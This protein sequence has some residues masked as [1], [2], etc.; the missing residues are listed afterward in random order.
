MSQQ[1]LLLQ[2]KGLYT[3][4]NHLSPQDTPQGG[5]LL[6]SNA[7]IDRNSIINSRR[8]YQIY[9][10]AMDSTVTDT[11]HQLLNYKKRLFR[12]WGIAAGQYLDWD[13]GTG[14]FS[15]FSFSLTASTNSN[16]TI[17]TITSTENLVIGMY[18]TGSGVV[19]N[20]TIVSIINNTSIQ[21]S[22]ATTTSLSGT[23]LFFTY[24]IQEVSEGVRLK[25][26]ESN[27]NFYFTT[28]NGIQKIAVSSAANLSSAF[29]T[30][31]GGLSALD[32]SAT[33]GTV[34]TGFLNPDSSCAYRIVWGINDANNNEIL[35]APGSR[36]IVNNP[37]SN[38]ENV[39][40]NITIPQGTTTSYFYQIYRTPQISLVNTFTITGNTNSS[41]TISGLV[42]TS[43]LAV[44]MII[45]GTNI[46]SNTTILSIPSVD[47][48][49]ISNSATGSTLG[50]VFTVLQQLTGGTADPGDEMQLAFEGNILVSDLNNGFVIITDIADDS[51]L[52]AYLYTNQNSGEGILQSNYPPPLSLDICAF[53]NYTFYANSSDLQQ[54]NLALLSI[55]QF[56]SGTSFIKVSQ[57]ASINTYT[58][59]SQSIACH[60][61]SNFT[62]D[63][64]SSTSTLIAGQSISGANIPF[65]A[66]IVSIDSLTQVTISIAATASS[67]TDGFMAGYESETNKFI[68]ISQ[69]P[70]PGQQV[71]ETAASLVRIINRNASEILYAYTP[72]D[73]P[74]SVPGQILLQTR[75][76]STGPFFLT[77]DSSSTTGTQFN[78]ALTTTQTTNATSTNQI[79]P[80]RIYYSKLQEPE[81]VPIVNFFDI[82][83][84]D[85][86]IIRILA[87]RDNLFILKEEGIYRLT[88]TDPTS[89][90]VFPFD[91]STQITASDSAVVLNNLIYLFSNQGIATISDTG[92]AIISR[93]IEGQ[94][95]PLLS[96]PYINFATATFGVTYETDRSYYLYTVTN[97]TDTFPTQCFRYNTFTQTWT[98]LDVSKR[99]GL[100]NVNDDLLYLGPTDINFLEQERKNFDRTDYADREYSILLATNSVSENIIKLPSLVNVAINDVVVQT[101]YLT[102]KQYN[103][104]LTKLDN[105]S[106]LSPHNYV[107]TFT[108]VAGVNL[109]NQLDT[110]IAA[111]A[112]DPGRIAVTGHTSGASYVALE[113]TGAAS[114][115]DLQICF[116]NLISLLNNDAGVGSHNYQNSS[117]TVDYEFNIIDTIPNSNQIVSTYSYPLIAGPI[118]VYQAIAVTI[119]FIPQSLGDV[120]MTKHVS[121]GTFIFEDASFT[122]AEVAYSTDLSANFEG[123]IIDGLGNGIFG[124]TPF[125]DGVFG[126]SGSGVPFRTYLPQGKQRCRY[127]NVQFSH[128]IAREIFYLYGISLTYNPMSQRGYR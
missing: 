82:G 94:L 93:P 35:G 33:L 80:N 65:G 45:T 74:S 124:N 20:T 73:A 18:V 14:N 71:S 81:S 16:T 96:A 100:V 30:N 116:N 36:V 88:G 50:V 7:V 113:G 26:I 77:V 6:A 15:T 28:S 106:L 48:V 9:G 112:I 39:N 120:S 47:T 121:E 24:N 68:G 62:L 87:L 79:F 1:S 46:P 42:D 23:T 126:G 3:Y 63:N 32:A 17:D 102:V 19:A 104:L 76:L 11:A 27:G 109:S 53:K 41:T 60:T 2:P 64:I 114:F 51:F 122:S 103:R 127:V 61:H 4:F 5:L 70:T 13:D 108:T 83:P 12:H 66:Y 31:A 99:C 52:G 128:Y 59:K 97:T 84:K 110:L 119:Q 43:S 78:P 118:T 8:G 10:N 91:F 92:V 115:I 123:D 101:Q 67:S 69:F 98:L 58:F 44:G 37:T 95:I 90:T 49:T 34:G 38:N 125:G 55:S 75:N 107:S 117:N 85:K 57:G 72:D 89:F 25:S 40:L 29:I 21:V 22:I 86:Q 54:L 111:I 105:D 56:V